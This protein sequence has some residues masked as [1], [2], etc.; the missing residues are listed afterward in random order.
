MEGIKKKV[1]LSVIFL[2]HE[3]FSAFSSPSMFTK[4]NLIT[5][6]VKTSSPIM[7]E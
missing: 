4:N 3:T 5:S 1:K 7:N 6:N 2:L